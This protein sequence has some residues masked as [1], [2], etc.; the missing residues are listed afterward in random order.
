MSKILGYKYYIE[1]NDESNE[2]KCTKIVICKKFN[3]RNK[4][5]CLNF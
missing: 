1:V 3:P 2:T 5:H 4:N